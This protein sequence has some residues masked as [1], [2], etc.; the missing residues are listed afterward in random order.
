MPADQLI[1]GGIVF[2]NYS[3]PTTMMGGGSQ[4]MAVHKLPGGL[5]VI[6][7]LGPDEADITWDGFFFEDG[8]YTKAL[9]LDGMR[10]AGQVLPLIW[11]GQ[12]RSVLI[13]NFIYKVRRL[14][15]WVIYNITCT[16]TQNP[17]LGNLSSQPSSI[18]G[19]VGSDLNAAASAA[20]S[21]VG[22]SIGGAGGSGL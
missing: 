7:T 5:R 16:V 4:A 6:D 17:A 13:N 15:N 20:T 22:T 19:Q 12:Y 1:L 18:D 2:D 21:D 8:A 11:G 9:T 10:A 14:P 3:A